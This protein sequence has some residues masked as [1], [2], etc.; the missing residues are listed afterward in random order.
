MRVSLVY[1][2]VMTAIWAV[3]L[4]WIEYCQ[5]NV[6]AAAQGHT[7]TE[8]NEMPVRLIERD[9]TDVSFTEKMKKF[10]WDNFMFGRCW[11][12][13]VIFGRTDVKNNCCLPYT[14]AFK[15]AWINKRK[16]SQTVKASSG[17]ITFVLLNFINRQ[18]NSW[19]N[20]IKGI[21]DILGNV[22]LV[23][24]RYCISYTLLKPRDLSASLTFWPLKKQ[25]SLKLCCV[26]V[27]I[28]FLPVVTVCVCMCVYVWVCLRGVIMG[29]TL[30]LNGVFWRYNS[31]CQM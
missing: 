31:A 3:T 4:V 18:Q 20:I 25:F 19:A 12:S 1:V 9:V 26:I 28:S 29:L 2:E 5:I 15:H 11:S 24:L 10:E 14:W 6:K 7:S 30:C 13:L 27:L 8:R 21:T 17:G 22:L 23:I 16:Q